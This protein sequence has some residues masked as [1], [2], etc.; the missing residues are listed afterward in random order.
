MR[1]HIT[2]FILLTLLSATLHAQDIQV[3]YIDKGQFHQQT[4]SAG[5]GGAVGF[6]FD[7]SVDKSPSGTVTAASV[8]RP[9]KTVDMLELDG[10][11]LDFEVDFASKALL[12]LSY[13]NEGT[14]EMSITG[15]TDGTQTINLSFGDLD[16]YPPAPHVLNYDA[17]QMV[18]PSQPLVISWNGW[19]GGT[20]ND[21]IQVE[22]Y[23]NDNEIYNSPGP[24]E[25]NSLDGTATSV[26]IPAN[27]LSANST[28]TVEVVFAKPV[29]LQ[30]YNFAMFG[31]EPAGA[32]VF[33]RLTGLSVQTTT[34]AS[35]PD[36][37]LIAIVKGQNFE[38]DGALIPRL[39]D[40][41]N[42]SG[43]SRFGFEAFV[44]GAMSGSVTSASVTAPGNVVTQLSMDDDDW[45]LDRGY[46]DKTEMDG[47][48]P[49]GAYTVTVNTQND[50]IKILSL[51][52]PAD[53]YPN[54][55]RVTN[56]EAAQ[57]IDSTAAFTLNFDAFSGG[58]TDDFVML[59]I[60][61]A[62]LFGSSRVYESPGPAD[63]GSLNGTDT[64]ASIPATTLSPGMQYTANLSFF[65]IVGS[66]PSYSTALAA[67]QKTTTFLIHTSGGTD[68]EG[69]FLMRTEPPQG[70]TNVKDTSV[71]AFQ[72]SEP[73][74]PNVDFS[75]T[76]QWTGVADVNSFSYTW[77]D[78]NQRLFARYTPGLPLN[79]M[80]GWTLNPSA[81]PAS[82]GGGGG[83]VKQGA[84][85]TQFQ[86]AAGNPLEFAPQ[87]GNFMTAPNSNLSEKDVLNFLLI[88]AEIFIQDGATADPLEEFIFGLDAD[89]NGFN[90]SPTVTITKPGGSPRTFFGEDHGDEFEL[91]AEYAE[92]SDLDAH[93]PNG[94]FAVQFDGFR[95]GTQ[96]VNL[97]MPTDSYPNTPVVQNHAA[98]GSVDPSQPFTLTWNSMTSPG[99]DDV[100]VVF[101]ENENGRE[102]YETP[103][104][105]QM[106]ALAGTTT[107]VT[108]PANTLPPGRTV[109][110]EVAFIKA[111]DIKD[112]SEMPYMDVLGVAAFAKATIFE[113]TTTGDPIVPTLDMVGGSDSPFHFRILGEKKMTYTIESSSDFSNWTFEFVGNA[114]D[115]ISGAMGEFIFYDWSGGGMSRKFYRARE[116]AYFGDF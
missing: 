16:N 96:T 107:S 27:T 15:A 2:A 37:D 43:S 7:A 17:L 98:L 28:Y 114:D 84:L 21:L 54:I 48:F 5:P 53:N 115:N 92:K 20:G 108:I 109:E 26:T 66:D 76:I 68:T 112:R 13:P 100:V 70:T 72:F 63:M 105:G 82:E 83:A 74:D 57:S 1:T 60:E 32:A 49:A 89:L 116:G 113:I 18:D 45:D 73:M 69:P 99:E 95:D 22:I 39:I 40:E 47:E 103:D 3:F 67:F 80:I 34:P 42:S 23:Q 58:T 50:G 64:S 51:T 41:Y 52:I 61:Q 35:G 6:F 55:P 110:A 8:E 44:D 56:W 36:A 101:I 65:R 102:I 75:Q 77:A 25:M 11:F 106:G 88:K 46:S 79:T 59:E 87:S 30:P 33:T 85:A 12:D 14:Y 81:G 38:Q 90:T 4:S 62:G 19:T 93:I 97:N 29:D 86:D 78:N 104:V 71:V 9:D 24:G 111:A 94:M 10:G 31:P 91:E